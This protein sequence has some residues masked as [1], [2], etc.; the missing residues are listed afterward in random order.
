MKRP[1]DVGYRVRVKRVTDLGEVLAHVF[2]CCSE[3]MTEGTCVTGLARSL[4]EEF[5]RN[6][7]SVY[8]EN[9]SAYDTREVV[10]VA[11]PIMATSKHP[12]R[13]ALTPPSWIAS[14]TARRCG[15]VC[16][17]TVGVTAGKA[18][19]GRTG[20]AS[21]PVKSARAGHWAHDAIR[22]RVVQASSSSVP[23]FSQVGGGHC[24]V[25]D[26]PG[27]EA[28]Q[29]RSSGSKYPDASSVEGLRRQSGLPHRSRPRLAVSRFNRDATT[30]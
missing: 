27:G 4:A 16:K 7:G 26:R 2:G 14:L 12:I 1:R 23:E 28:R 21:G 11:G 29:W 6:V 25:G 3:I 9:M 19:I 20:G 18:G 5:A 24:F 17:K 10:F 30:Q 8:R 13:A 15:K 22:M